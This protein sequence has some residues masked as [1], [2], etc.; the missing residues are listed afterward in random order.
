MLV[1]LTSRA[2]TATYEKLSNAAGVLT[3]AKSDA[4]W[5]KNPRIIYE[6]ALLKL[7][8]PE[9]DNSQEALLDR[10]SAVEEKAKNTVIV[11]ETPIEENISITSPIISAYFLTVRPASLTRTISG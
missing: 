9:L 3:K 1:K 11:A 10:L 8:R 6:L 2:K 4:R 5:V 7:T